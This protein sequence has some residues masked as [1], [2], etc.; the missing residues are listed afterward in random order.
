[1]SGSLKFGNIISF[2]PYLKIYNLI[3]YDNNLPKQFVVKNRN[4]IEFESGLSAVF[5]FR[6]DYSISLVFQ[7]SGLKNQIQGNKFSD[8]LY[9]I[10]FE[11]TFKN[12]LKAGVEF[13]LLFTRSFTV[14]VLKL[15]DLIF[16]GTIQEILKYLA[17]HLVGSI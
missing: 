7:Y 15:Q 9:F 5:F 2:N 1:M 13:G 12:K 8:P 11:K 14:E 10:A 17:C 4:Q 6:H 3:T 16:T